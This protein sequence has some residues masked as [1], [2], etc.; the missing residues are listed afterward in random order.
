MPK[1]S[2]MLSLF[3]K[4]SMIISVLLFLSLLICI[5]LFPSFGLIFTI[6]F[7]L[8]GFVLA[9]FPVIEKH[10]QAYLQGKISRGIYVR[11]ILFDVAG[12]LLTLILAAL[13]GRYMAE[14]ATRQ[15]GNELTKLIAGILIGLLIGLAVGIFVKQAWGRLVKFSSE[16]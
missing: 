1:G 13:L 11:N 3:R 5:W 14:I 15:I 12:I 4:Y 10:R 2:D 9:S 8:C 7:I 16:N 6:L